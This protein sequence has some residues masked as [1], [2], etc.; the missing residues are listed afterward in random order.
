MSLTD[1]TRTTFATAILTRIGDAL[2]AVTLLRKH[3]CNRLRVTD[4]RVS[5]A[6]CV[7]VGTYVKVGWVS[8]GWGWGE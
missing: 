1:K 7:N 3:I 4:E 6:A 8:V 5:W 2:T